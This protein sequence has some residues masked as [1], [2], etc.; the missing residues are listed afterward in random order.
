MR[1]LHLV[2]LGLVLIETLRDKVYFAKE[3]FANA[4]DFR[5]ESKYYNNASKIATIYD[6]FFL[7]DENFRPVSFASRLTFEREMFAAHCK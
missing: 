5:Y 7:L 1:S 6:Q 3:N 2:R 4:S